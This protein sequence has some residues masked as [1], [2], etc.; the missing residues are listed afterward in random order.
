MTLGLELPVW[1]L[2][3]IS[4]LKRFDENHKIFLILNL[5]RFILITFKNLFHFYTLRLLRSA[6]LPTNFDWLKLVFKIQL[7]KSEAIKAI[8]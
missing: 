2:T 4:R 7:F 8:F 5:K 1:K 6:T 3:I